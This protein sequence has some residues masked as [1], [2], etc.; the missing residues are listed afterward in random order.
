M[1]IPD[2]VR[3]FV[4]FVHGSGSSRHSPRNQYLAQTLQEGGL[5]TLLFDVLTAYEEKSELQNMPPEGYKK[6]VV[7]PGAF[8]LFE[9]AGALEEAAQLARDWFQRYLDGVGVR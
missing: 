1:S 7:V 4:L 6:L 5:A 9:E 3:G 2:D 8:Q